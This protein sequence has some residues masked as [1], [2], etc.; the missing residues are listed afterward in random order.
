MTSG[1]PSDATANAVR[2][3]LVAAKYAVDTSATLAGRAIKN[4][5]SGLCLDDFNGSTTSGSA[6]VQWSCSC[7]IAQRWS[8][9]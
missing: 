6:A 9:L 4:G 2:A 7:Q 3:N 5:N 8:I 1:Y